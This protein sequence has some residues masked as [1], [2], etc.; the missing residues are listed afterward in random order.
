MKAIYDFLSLSPDA[1]KD[2]IMTFV[3]KW[4]R[5]DLELEFLSNMIDA[6]PFGATSL[7][8]EVSGSPLWA[9][10]LEK[11]LEQ[12]VTALK[13]FNPRAAVMKGDA[14]TLFDVLNVVVEETQ[15]LTANELSVR[16]IDP[17]K[18]IYQPVHIK[19]SGVLKPENLRKK[20]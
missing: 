19:Y 10:R 12:M 7:E 4:T 11:A 5:N 20:S 2:D 13:D 1:V 6:L 9:A 8:N 15:L 17:N 3:Q 14:F 16:Y 18:F